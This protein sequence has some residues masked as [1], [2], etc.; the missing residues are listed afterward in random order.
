MGASAITLQD[1]PGME[2]CWNFR[3]RSIKVERVVQGAGLPQKM[4]SI[5]CPNVRYEEIC[6]RCM[7]V[8]SREG[9]LK[10]VVP[11]PGRSATFDPG[12]EWNFRS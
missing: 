2:L 12:L 11:A 9:Y 8:R 5:C 1:S 10:A 4:A 7:S 6:I 3:R